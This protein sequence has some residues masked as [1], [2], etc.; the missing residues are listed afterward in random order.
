[1]KST[2]YGN[3]RALSVSYDNGMRPTQWSIP[4]VMRWNYAY[5]NF[6]ENTG[7]VTYAQNLDDATLDRSYDYDHVGRLIEARTGSE[8]RGHLIGQGGAQDGP[9]AHSYRYD[10]MG[11]MWYRVGWGGWFNPWLEQWPSYTNNRLTT[12]PWTGTSMSYDAAG[13]LTNDGYQGYIYDATGQQT[14]ASGGT[15][16]Q[17]YDGDRLRVKRVENG[18]TTYYLRSSVLGGQ[19]ISELSAGGVL[20]RGYVYLGGQMLAIQQSS[21][22]SWVH[23]D[24]MTKSQR[25]TNSAGTITSTIDLDP[26]G[27]ETSRSSNQAF[28]PH[29]YTSYERD[30][31]GGDEAM[32]R[33]Y[34]GKWHRFVQPDPYDGSYDLTNPQ[35]FNR[36]AYVQNEPVNSVDPSGLL[37][38]TFDAEGNWCIWGGADPIGTE[39]G[40]IM[41]LIEMSN[42]GMLPSIGPGLT[43]GPGETTDNPESA[44]SGSTP[45]VFPC[46]PTAAELLNRSE[47]QNALTDAF[48]DSSVGTQGEHEEGGWIFMNRHSELTIV[49]APPGDSRMIDLNNPPVVAGSM[50]VA[51]FHTHPGTNGAPVPGRPG[52]T[53]GNQS[54]PSPADTIR[55]FHKGS[56]GIIKSRY[57]VK[58]FG[59]KFRGANPKRALPPRQGAGISGYAGNSTNPR[60]R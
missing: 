46:P 36:Y 29:R 3:N 28:Q 53:Y 41:E 42:P 52:Y 32:M 50:L 18:T 15:L 59:P 43:R 37:P 10:Q 2:S 13:N 27:G 6:N 20:Q 16:T 51:D 14:Y 17:S 24:P 56:P 1:L 49:R 40:R 33:R 35:S 12:N 44:P 38:C 25:I 31:N 7:R 39:R 26:W 11:N 58:S 19:V 9:Y 34:T 4:D 48:N 45:E 23:Q 22:V 21:Q 47:V 54:I 8:A 60:C 55:A 30:G 5:N 57:G